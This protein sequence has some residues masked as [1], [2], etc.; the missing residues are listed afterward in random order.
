M[1][2]NI[3]RKLKHKQTR[4][5]KMLING[6]FPKTIMSNVEKIENKIREEA[7]KY[8]KSEEWVQIEMEIRGIGMGDGI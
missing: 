5:C 2:Y 8:G 6:K 7:K 4:R 3:D 1:A